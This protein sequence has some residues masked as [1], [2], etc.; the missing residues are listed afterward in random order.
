MATRAQIKANGDNAKKSTGPRTE[1]GKARVANNALKHGLL[2]RDTVLPG[3]DPAE[4]DQQ[5]AAL[6]A[7]LQPANS[8][9]TRWRTRSGDGQITGSTS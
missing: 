5:L 9:K 2:A 1:E 8:P 4:F 7:D 6:E 3:E